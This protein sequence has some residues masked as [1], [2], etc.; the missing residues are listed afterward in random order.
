MSSVRFLTLRSLCLTMEGL[1]SSTVFSYNSETCSRTRLT[2]SAF[3]DCRDYS[4]GP[5]CQCRPG[6]YGNGKDCVAEGKTLATPD[7]PKYVWTQLDRQTYNQ[8]EQRPSSNISGR[9]LGCLSKCL[10]SAPIGCMSLYEAPQV[11][12][13]MFGLRC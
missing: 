12:D 13:L 5:C 6:F 11:L 2:C 1:F 4:T 8:S 9:H 10:N 7:G 3:A